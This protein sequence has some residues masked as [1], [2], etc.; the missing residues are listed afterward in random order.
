MDLQGE[1]MPAWV[2]DLIERC[3]EFESLLVPAYID[4]EE[5]SRVVLFPQMVFF[6][7]SGGFVHLGIDEATG[8]LHLGE[9]VEAFLPSELADEPSISP[10]FVDLTENCLGGGPPAKI[11]ST[12]FY[13]DEDSV[14]AR[15]LFRGVVFEFEGGEGVALDP[16]SFSGIRIG[17]VPDFS[18]VMSNLSGVDAVKVCPR[19][20]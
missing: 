18:V 1:S 12:T 4:L 15:G 6:G 11:K 16:L 13:L 2:I 5:R 17:I 20:R 9:S 7:S 14:P 19:S 3:Y 8:Q 10:T